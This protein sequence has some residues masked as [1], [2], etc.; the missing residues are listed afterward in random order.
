MALAPVL[1]SMNIIAFKGINTLLAVSQQSDSYINVTFM[2]KSWIVKCPW[3]LPCS[4]F[5]YKGHSHWTYENVI[6]RKLAIFGWKLPSNR[7]KSRSK[8]RKKNRKSEGDFFKK[9]TYKMSFQLV[10]KK[11]PRRACE[12][13][14]SCPW[15]GRRV[16]DISSTGSSKSLLFNSS[17]IAWRR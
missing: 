9:T 5:T 17:Q 13:Q 15:S 11:A 4:Y 6:F 1:F 10:M 7:T 12:G 14:D 3:A 16:R 2:I 8:D